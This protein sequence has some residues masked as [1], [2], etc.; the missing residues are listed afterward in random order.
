VAHQPGVTA[1]DI[2]YATRRRAVRWDE[3][4]IKLSDILAAIQAIGYR[5][6][7]TTPPAPS[8]FP[9]ASAALPCG[10]CSWPASA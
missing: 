10:A 5:A 9:S 4:R 8:R 6:I 7:P 2:N 1:V 3:R